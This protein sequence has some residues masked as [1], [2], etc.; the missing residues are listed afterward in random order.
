MVFV[1]ENINIDELIVVPDDGSFPIQ[2]DIGV[3]DTVTAVV[4][5][6]GQN[7][8][9]IWTVDDEAYGGN[10]ASITHTSSLGGPVT[11]GVTVTNDVGCTDEA[12]VTVE[13][14]APTV[15]VPNVFTPNGDNQNDFFFPVSSGGVEVLEMKVFNRWGQLVFDNEDL[16]RGW[17]GTFNGNPAPS[18][19][20]IYRILY[21]K[22]DTD[23]A[24]IFEEKGD[25][26]LLR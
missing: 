12:A 4:S 26:T 20:Y 25:V 11:Y 16:D 21:K 6:D 1:E 17:D 14:V 19:V 22:V 10:T 3:V 23:D 8:T 2:I 5:P 18:D 13:F 7:L 9:Y 24:E 15:A